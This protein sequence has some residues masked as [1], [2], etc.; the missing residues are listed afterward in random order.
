[1]ESVTSCIIYDA[2]CRRLFSETCA[3]VSLTTRL[4]RWTARHITPPTCPRP[5]TPAGEGTV[6]LCVSVSMEAWLAALMPVCVVFG[7]PLLLLNLPEAS[8]TPPSVQTPNLENVP[9]KIHF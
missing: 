7:P 9:S 4:L 3:V 5:L 6:C 2:E 1:M 8:V